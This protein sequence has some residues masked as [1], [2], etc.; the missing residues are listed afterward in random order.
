MG[1]E[2]RPGQ[3]AHGMKASMSMERNMAKEN[4][5]GAISPVTKG[6]SIT[7]ACRGRVYTHGMT[8]GI[9]MESGSKIEWKD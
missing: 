3:M 8:V 7:T 9:L 5:C 2:S 6:I 4:S 1:K